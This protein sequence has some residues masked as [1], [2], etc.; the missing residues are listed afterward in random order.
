M[1]ATDRLESELATWFDETATPMTD[2]DIDLILQRTAGM[3]Q[4]PRWTFLERWI[5]MRADTLA[6]P[7][8]SPSMR[9][10]AILAALLILAATIVVVGVGSRPTGPVYE[11]IAANGLVAYA[12]DSDIVVVDPE[13]GEASTLIGG[14]EVDR[15]PIYSS[16]GSRLAFVRD[17]SEGDD[18]L[19]VVPTSGGTPVRIT[20]EPTS[21]VSPTWSP[22]D[23]IIAFTNGDLVTAAT[24]G[25]E[26]R[27]LPIGIDAQLARF[28]PPDGA[29]IMFVNGSNNTS[30]HLVRRDGSELVSIAYPDGREVRD[31][32]LGWTADGTGLVIVRAASSD[33]SPR[34]EAHVLTVGADGTVTGDEVIGPPLVAGPWGNSVSP[35]GSRVVVGAAED[36]E[37][38]AWRAAIVPLDPAEP[39]TLTG[40]VFTNTD[41]QLE[42]SPDGTMIVARDEAAGATWLLD[43]NA[44]PG[45]G[46]QAPWHDPSGELL[47]WQRVMP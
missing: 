32:V 39:T 3:R 30:L 22:D 41:V 6:V 7:S 17:N 40:P 13:T 29:Q 19:F 46:R 12:A 14:P 27:A 21:I 47:V 28:R 38:D 45:P 15:N 33:A 10:L 20:A 37:G 23:A 31:N 18:A 42:W 35:E 2:D 34:R 36:G 5:P 24:D 25:S 11:A 4:R 43:A 9:T 1:T 16:D 26:M 8:R 44:D